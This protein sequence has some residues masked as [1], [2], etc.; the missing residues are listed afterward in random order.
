VT[1]SYDLPDEAAT[2]ALGESL[3]RA[4]PPGAVL[5]LSGPLGAGKTTLVR[6][7]ARAVGST[8]SVASPTYAYVHEY[9]T[10]GGPLV[11]VDAYRLE[12]P[13]RLWSMGLAEMLERARLTVIE[14]GEG[15]VGELDGPL[16]VRLEAAGGGRRAT[17]TGG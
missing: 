11:H 14:W 9:P 12:D 16:V 10:P 15:L 7:L 17:V 1:G 2:E 5:V 4:L 3:G 6:G 8:A 13:R